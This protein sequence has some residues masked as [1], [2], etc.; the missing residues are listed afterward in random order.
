[1]PCS[2]PWSRAPLLPPPAQRPSASDGGAEGLCFA[3]WGRG[4]LLRMVGQRVA[5]SHAGAEG[6]CFAS[7]G[8]GGLAAEMNAG[9]A[10]LRDVK[11]GIGPEED[12]RFSAGSARGVLVLGS[13][14]D[15]RPRQWRQWGLRGGSRLACGPTNGTPGPGHNDWFFGCAGSSGWASGQA[16]QA[17]RVRHPRV[18]LPTP[19]RREPVRQRQY[20][21]LAAA[22]E[23]AKDLAQDVSTHPASAGG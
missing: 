9:F 4:S 3:W 23:A 17:R 7:W 12:P 8:S 21:A 22:E 2:A 11:H 20:S 5:A 16:R 14:A 1:M 18:G 6:L 19:Q 15:L 13:G 10:L